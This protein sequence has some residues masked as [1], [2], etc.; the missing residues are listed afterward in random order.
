MPVPSNAVYEVSERARDEAYFKA[1]YREIEGGGPAAMKCGGLIDL[2]R[3]PPI[4]VHSFFVA[5]KV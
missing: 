5:S 2:S 1:L 3:M 4:E